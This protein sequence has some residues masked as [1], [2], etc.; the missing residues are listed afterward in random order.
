MNILIISG[1]DSTDELAPLG[2]DLARKYS[3][4]DLVLFSNGPV[5]MMKNATGKNINIENINI[6]PA[7]AEN[8][9]E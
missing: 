2:L 7:P 3:N 8:R 6:E 1:V 5:K 9:A 4:A